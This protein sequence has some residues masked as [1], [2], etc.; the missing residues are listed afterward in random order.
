[1]SRSFLLIFFFA[2]FGWWPNIC[3]AEVYHPGDNRLYQGRVGWV[4]IEILWETNKPEQRALLHY[5]GKNKTYRLIPNRDGNQFEERSLM[6]NRPTGVSWQLYPG[7]EGSRLRGTRLMDGTLKNFS[8][9]EKSATIPSEIWM[10][11][12]LAN[13]PPETLFFEL[14]THFTGIRYDLLYYG[15]TMEKPPQRLDP[16]NVDL[17]WLPCNFFGDDQPEALVELRIDDYIHVVRV[18]YRNQAGGL[19]WVPEALWFKR[20]NRDAQPCLTDPPGPA[21][22]YA[23][24][25]PVLHPSQYVLTGYTYGGNC[26]FI[27]R[28]DQIEYYVWQ[29]EAGGLR[30]LFH[31][32]ARSYWYASPDPAPIKPPVFREF[33]F[34]QQSQGVYP[35]VLMKREAIF[36]YPEGV[37]GGQT[38]RPI[39]FKTRYINLFPERF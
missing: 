9:S 10:K 5:P 35:L 34:V 20:T 39:D 27:N 6:D 28:G 1:M 21:F 17:Q 38:L 25:E 37:Q 16:A 15:G 4:R 19:Q 24:P 11:K 12:W 31:E 3:Q 33:S 32:P 22:F 7:E 30:Q 13:P 36:A 8:L 23:Q 2:C 14:C 18:G 29:V 26:T